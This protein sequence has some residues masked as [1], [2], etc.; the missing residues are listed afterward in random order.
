ME[1]T[2]AGQ[3]FRLGRYPIHF[4]LNGRMPGS[5]VLGCAIHGTF[6]RAINIHGT[7]EIFVQHNVIFNVMGG[8]VFLEDGIET[9][10][11][12]QYNLAIKVIASTS[13]LNDDITPASFWITHPDNIVE[14][15]AAAG[16]T[17][18]GFWY[19]LNAHPE[20][21]SHTS[22][23][24]LRKVPLASFKNNTAHSMGWFGLWIF[25]E[26]YPTKTG[27]CHSTD[28]APA[29]FESLTV[30]NSD[31]AAEWVLCGAVQFT[32]MLAYNNRLAGLEAKF[33]AN[34]RSARFAD[35]APMFN[36][37]VM[38]AHVPELETTSHSCMKHGMILP[39]GE[40][41]LVKG[42]KFINFDRAGCS[43][44]GI[45]VAAGCVEFCGAFMYWFTDVTYVNTPNRADF[46]HQFEAVFHDLDGS[47]SGTVGATVTPTQG[48]LPADKC[49]H[50]A[51]FSK[52]HAAS[53]CQRPVWFHR[54]SF[55]HVKPIST[56]SKEVIITNKY[57]SARSMYAD[58]RVTHKK[59]YAITLLSGESTQIHFVDN[60]PF[61]NFSYDG[62][63]SSLRV[64]TLIS[65]VGS[66]Q[67]ER[68]LEMCRSSEVFS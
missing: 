47:L 27:A 52:N 2:Y 59:G 50:I 29:V 18:F 64:S 68:L 9:N 7:H 43:A 3:A 57:G 56:V 54:F 20:G 55:N 11:V 60:G 46:R 12:I 8:A 44:I 40:G 13:L 51:A 17:H 15:N 33:I 45:A 14:H 42:A 10:N 61:L 25:P 62:M 28:Y 39:V 66:C 24:C 36:N 26:Y 32:D 22:S 38:I 35:N 41:M 19:R 23:V 6:N 49:A 53:V 58:K 21:P 48:T 63:I 4:H 34:G 1:V 65:F 5:Y 30:W 31:K 37:S 67:Q 16:G